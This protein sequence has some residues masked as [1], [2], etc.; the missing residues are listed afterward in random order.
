MKCNICGCEAIV[1][2]K[3]MILNKY[4]CTYYHC[5]NCS[6]LFTQEPYWIEEAYGKAIAITDTGIIARNIAFCE[7]LLGILHLRY[8]SA[9]RILDY[10]AGYGIMVRMLRDNGVNAFWYDK[11]CDN[12]FAQGF[13]YRAETKPDIVIAFEV[14]EHLTDPKKFFCEVLSIADTVVITTELLPPTLT[15][16]STNDW[17]YFAPETGQHIFFYSSRTLKKIAEYNK[18]RHYSY[19]NFQ[20]LTRD[21]QLQKLIDE[22]NKSPHRKIHIINKVANL[23]NRYYDNSEEDKYDSLT[24]SDHIAMIE[25][26]K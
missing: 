22:Q 10:G 24:W 18:C 12:L 1:L 9:P 11:Y 20:I 3:S 23:L 15:M 14:A 8:L 13:E 19:N 5:T 26:L 6:C 17:W 16:K 21:V 4:E 25:K 7:G 2:F